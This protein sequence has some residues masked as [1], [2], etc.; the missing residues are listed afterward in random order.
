[1]DCCRSGHP[2]FLREPTACLRD[3]TAALVCNQ[4]AQYPYGPLI[5]PNLIGSLIA[6]DVPNHLH[7]TDMTERMNTAL[8][9]ARAIW[10]RGRFERWT[11]HQ[12]QTCDDP[13]AI[14][15]DS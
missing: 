9:I 11:V 5:V 2:A 13:S 15:A 4:T 6:P 12:L 3:D 8:D 10:P 14:T 7:P 1:M